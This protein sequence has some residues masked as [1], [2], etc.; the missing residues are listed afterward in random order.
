MGDLIRTHDWA[1]TSL[2]PPEAW[3]QSLK[4]AIRIMLSSRYAMWMAWG[5]DLIFFCNDAYRPTLGDKKNWLGARSDSV[6]TE[7][8]PDIGPRIHRVLKTGEATWDEGLLLFLERSGFAEETYHTFSYSPLAD[9]EGTITGMLCVVTEDTKRVIGERRLRVLRDLGLR[10]TDI[11]TS[12]EVWSAVEACLATEA[13]DLPFALAYRGATDT[14]STAK[15]ELAC[16]L[17]SEHIAAPATILL[18]T[19]TS[20]PLHDMQGHSLRL[21]ALSAK[22]GEFPAGPWDKP[23]VE[24]L[25]L[26]ISAQGHADPIGTFIAGLNPYRPLDADYRGFLTLF[27]GQIA[28][29][30]ASA[31]AYAAEHARAEALAQIDKAKTAFFSNISHEFRTPLTLMIGPLEDAINMLEPRD[32]AQ[33]ELLSVA[34]RSSLRLLRLVNSLLDFSRIEAG[35]MNARYRATDLAAITQDIAASFRSAIE[36]ADLRFDVQCGP[37]SDPVWVDHDMWEKIVL[38]L[39]SNAF[40]FTFHGTIGV[41]LEEFEGEVRLSVRDTGT[42]IPSGELPRLF[43]RFHRVDGAKGRSFEG[44][45]IGLALVQELITLHGGRITVESELGSGSTFSVFLPYG[46]AHLPP[47]RVSTDKEAGRDS[48]RSDAYVEEALSWLPMN[49]DEDA[50]GAYPSGGEV[51]RSAGRV[52]VADDN[53]DLRGYISR[54]LSAHGYVVE[55]VPNG[56]A[57]LNALH[58]ALP[59]ILVTDVMMPELDGI[60]LV[61]E[62]RADASLRELPVIMLSA[63][64]GVDAKIEGLATAADD[65]LTKPFSARELVARVAANVATAR[66]RREATERL[67]AAQAALLQANETLEE[68]VAERTSERDRLWRNSRDLLLVLDASGMFR[69]ASPAWTTVLGWEPDEIVGR[70]HLDF[71]HEEDRESARASLALASRSELSVVENRMLHKDGGFRWISWVAAPE[72]NLIYASGR[73]ITGEKEARQALQLSEARLRAIFETSFQ[74]QGLLT[75]DGTLLDSNATSLEVIDASREEV[76][77]KPYWDTPWFT[78]TAQM[79][80]WVRDAISSV[81]AGDTVRREIALNV[82][83]GL[84]N[85][86]FSLRAVHDN[87]GDIVALVPEAVDITERRHAE[88]QLRQAQKIEA[89]GRLTGGVAHDFNNLL[90]VISGGLQLMDRGIEGAKRQRMVDG[91]RQAVERGAGLCRQLLAFSRRQPLRPQVLDISKHIGEMRELLERSLRGDIYVRTAFAED[92]WTVE[93]DPGELELVI[94]NLAVNARDAM[95]EGGGIVISARNISN[96]PGA[97][98]PGDF[99]CIAISDCGVGMPAAVVARAFEP[100]FT[101]KE[102]GKGSG[103][104]LAQTHGF[105]RASGG[106]V[107]IDSTLNVGT[108]IS[109]FLPRSL[110]YVERPDRAVGEVALDTG[111][112]SAGGCVLLVEDDDEVAAL[113]AEMLRQLGYEVLRVASAAAALGALANGR[114]VDIVFSDV[115]MP[116]TMNGIALAQEIHK[117]R[118]GLP[119]LLATG[120][121]EPEA[122]AAGAS[123]TQ[124]LLKPYTIE[125]LGGAL[126]G[127]R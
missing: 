124:V 7:I 90:M 39:L 9:D 110:K 25:L 17:S 95:P 96:P 37:L 107:E 31:N 108:T 5:P 93:V 64:A 87:G 98:Y 72:Q 82:H 69:A 111:A 117:R 105:V 41:Y 101:T 56:R 86:D 27:V 76:L 109:L 50:A 81:A 85:F 127:V 119:V 92:L 14:S 71:V 43:E 4:I 70:Y 60:G 97:V 15:L 55:S 102:V 11:R 3:P 35:R 40:K 73:H 61:R 104:G 79:S 10:L 106:Y 8:W 16:G 19:E 51:A 122:L 103:L 18:G 100:F 53:A 20:W 65:Y 116:G 66:I 112:K 44:S 46:T 28:A 32:A 84:R 63:R 13:Q 38:N 1:G 59:D 57:A 48:I 123:H 58:T 62:I 49:A 26:P 113:T 126:S 68:R 36:R 125:D 114:A 78:G 99:V 83:A 52:L 77:G 24:A 89:L 22:Y 88:E 121:A 12:R 2:G 120:Y 115:M 80:E 30:L 91:M 45:G 74:L 34:H 23:P 6:W 42:G 67:R 29:A 47:D 54:L 21:E 33:R 118:P 94:L 75:P